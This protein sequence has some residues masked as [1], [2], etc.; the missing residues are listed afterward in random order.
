MFYTLNIK[1]FRDGPQN[2]DGRWWESNYW[3]IAALL[4]LSRDILWNWLAYLCDSWYMQNSLKLE[5]TYSSDKSDDWVNL[6]QFVWGTVFASY[7]S[8]KKIY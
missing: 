3:F 6:P 2:S 7:H 5:G 8:F 4:I 1:R